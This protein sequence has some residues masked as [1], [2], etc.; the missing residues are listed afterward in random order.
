MKLELLLYQTVFSSII[1]LLKSDSYLVLSVDR[2][3]L[4]LSLVDGVGK[5][6]SW[7]KGAGEGENELLAGFFES[8][9]FGFLPQMN[10]KTFE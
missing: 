9:C 1:P 10:T 3:S 8:L 4:I 2:H 5:K 7:R 6:N